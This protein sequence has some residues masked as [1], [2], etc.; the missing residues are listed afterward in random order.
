MLLEDIRPRPPPHPEQPANLLFRQ[1]E[2]GGIAGQVALVAGQPPNRKRPRGARE[3]GAQRD[4]PALLL[5]LHWFPSLRRGAVPHGTLSD[6][7][8]LGRARRMPPERRLRLGLTAFAIVILTGFVGYQVL[9][10]FTP[11]DALYMTVIT[12]S[13]VGF[14]EVVPLDESGRLF[15][16]VLIAAGLA[17]VAFAVASGAEFVLE[18]HMRRI[19]ERRRM[20]RSI[21]HL[22][23]HVII[24]GYGRVGRRLA[25]ELVAEGV[26]LVIV[27]SDSSRLERAVEHGY[28][29]VEGDSTEEHVLLEAGI[30]RAKA[31]VACV[32]SDADNVLTTLTAKGMRPEMS[33]IGRAKVEENEAKFRRAGADRV[34]APTTMGGRRI[35]QLLTRPVVAE[36]L[37]LVGGSGGLEYTF[38]EVPVRKGSSL[39]GTKLGDARIRETFG[40]T[41]LAIDHGDSQALDTHPD[42]DITLVAGDVLVV[43]GAVGEVSAMREHFAGSRRGV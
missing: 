35:A 6:D 26:P 28:P 43:I 10:G 39:I 18:G 27:D 31:L 40:C 1:D 37:E 11:L 9:E 8:A 14:G 7:R 5:W 36:F 41:V 29:Y 20:D 32:N 2:R 13:S 30:Q 23:G 22:E 21:Q 4:A 16:I 34:I 12:V 3:D 17:S 15:T 38:E 19:I 25:D 42:E 33:V 24:C